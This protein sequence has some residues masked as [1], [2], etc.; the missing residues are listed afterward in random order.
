[1]KQTSLA[2]FLC[3]AIVCQC[4]VADA[5]RVF[6]INPDP[7]KT[8]ARFHIGVTGIYATVEKG[9]VVTVDGT[10]PGTPAAGKFDK[11]DVILAVNGKSL[12]GLDPLVALGEAIGAAEASDGKLPFALKR[13][14]ERLQ[15]TVTIP[16]LGA[17]SETWPLDCQKSRTI[18]RQTADYI[19]KSNMLERP[20]L[21]QYLAALFLLSTGDDQYLPA[22]KTFVQLVPPEKVGSHTW[23]NGY[24]GILLGE[25]YL[26]TGD[27]S[28]LPTLKALCDNAKERQYYGGWNHWGGCGVGYVQGGLMNPAGAQVLT[29]LV[30]AQE[31]GVAVDQGTLDR[32]LRLFYRFA[33]HGAVPYGD[34][35][36]EGWLSANGKN[37]M[38]ACALAPLDGKPYKM[39]A[40]HMGLDM[41]DSYAW[42]LCGHTGGGFDAI[43]R[44]LAAVH[45]PK[46]R[47]HHYRRQLDKLAWH[48]DLSRH[49]KGG[50]AM[51]GGGR[52][53]SVIWGTGGMGLAYTAPLRTLRITGGP[54]TQYSKKV[55]EPAVP[56]GR[57]RD[58]EFLRT[59][60]CE[61]FGQEE[62]E[63]HQVYARLGDAYRK[64]LDEEPADT[65][66]LV[67]MMRHYNPI[68]RTMAARA[69]GRLG[70]V[71]EIVAALQHADPRVRRAGFDAITMYHFWSGGSE[72]GGPS[73]KVVSEKFLGTMVKTLNDPDA[74]LWELDGALLALSRAEQRDIVTNLEVV[75][76]FLTHEDWWLRQS[77][78]LAVWALSEDEK[79]L[80][81]ELPALFDCAVK[82]THVMPRR[83]YMSR[84]HKL[85]K[86][87]ETSPAMR[88]QLIAG[89]LR[90][91]NETTVETGFRATIG[92]N[93]TYETLRF[94]L[95]EAPEAAP[96]VI[97]ALPRVL[98]GLNSTM[99]TWVFTGDVWNN[100]GLVKCAQRLGNDAEPVIEGLRKMLPELKERRDLERKQR[101]RGLKQ[102]EN[103]VEEVSRLADPE[104]RWR[105]L[106]PV[107]KDEPQE[108]RYVMWDADQRPELSDS[109]L[110]R[111]PAAIPPDGMGKWS[112]PDFD[113]SAW[114]KANGAFGVW[115]AYFNYQ[116]EKFTTEM[117]ADHILLRRAF[118]L[119]DA[120]LPVLRL[121]VV[122]RDGADVYLNGERIYTT[123]EATGRPKYKTIRLDAKAAG[124]LRKGPN[125]LAVYSRVN[126]WLQ[127]PYCLIDAGLEGAKEIK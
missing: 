84:L 75:R 121:T 17:Y 33:G 26:R 80:E 70:A 20:G 101:G 49:P 48:Y 62:L 16:V 57:P 74:S 65:E 51:V 37:G 35:R 105:V 117:T 126:Y 107:S 23:N 9:L 2:A 114:K 67:K 118:Q 58:L 93:N 127:K 81:I 98:P 10:E 71:D 36:P 46:E 55:E 64:P 120:E 102:L 30:L 124:L 91:L 7:A 32:A 111:I 119:E 99:Y 94:F 12:E 92:L 43:W 21:C 60:Y 29:S 38:L 122:S 52:Y 40:Q 68:A 78:W 113:D 110:T 106:T 56:W 103:A 39:A 73:A 13:G 66:F 47:R 53:G 83:T 59:D 31:C 42:L 97:D 82:E 34:H 1:M 108:W 86:K 14:E 25:Y 79:L 5:E 19:V 125:K 76:K 104:T 90:A 109:G 22:V 24:H 100:P 69:L 77:S 85:L 3:V 72:E 50:F 6:K 41:A 27:A 116:G 8:F 88:K 28:A 115:K 61:G 112:S 15:A 45:T 44:G 123:N 11:G 87:K 63:P 95:A 96:Q 18:V 89:M 54:H 4:R